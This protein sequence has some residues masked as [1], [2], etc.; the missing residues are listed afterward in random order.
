META[1]ADDPFMYG[2]R[3]GGGAGPREGFLTWD[4]TVCGFNGG[5]H[6]ARKGRGKQWEQS[7]ER[8]EGWGR[9]VANRS[10]GPCCN[11]GKLAGASKHIK[12]RGL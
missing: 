9:K 8:G 7:V 3:Q 5:N 2:N 11:R 1:R 6:L 4:T 10:G 12:W